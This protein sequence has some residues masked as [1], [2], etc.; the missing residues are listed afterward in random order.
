MRAL[1]ELQWPDLPLDQLSSKTV[2]TAQQRRNREKLPPA[3]TLGAL[4]PHTDFADVFEIIAPRK[5]SLPSSGRLAIEGLMISFERLVTIRKQVAHT[6]P[7]RLDDA[8]FV[9]DQ[10]TTL[11]T[12]DP[13]TW[14]AL[15][16]TMARI[17]ENPAYV[18]GL[19]PMW[20][21]EEVPGTP[22]HNLPIP[23]FDD[24]G[25][26]GRREE[27]KKLKRLIKGS[28]PVVSVLGNGGIGKTALAVEA[29]YE[30]LDDPDRQFEAIV[31]V[32]AKSSVMTGTEVVAIT[33]AIKDSL[34]LFSQAATFLG[35][36]SE[37][38]PISE[39][40]S[41]L[42][43]F[44]VLLILDNLE[45]VL[46]PVLREFLADIPLGSKVIVTSRISLGMLD[47]PISLSSLSPDDA[48]NLLY[49]LCRA[50]G[51]DYLRGVKR[52]TVEEY[53]RQMSGHPSYIRWFVAGLQAGRRPEDL[54]SDDGLVLRFCMSNVYDYLEDAERAA[55]GVFQVLSGPKNMAEL[56]Y[57]NDMSGDEMERILLTL[58]TTNF[59]SMSRRSAAEHLDSAYFLSDFAKDYLDRWHPIARKR[60]AYLL[61][62]NQELKAQGAQ[63]SV[64]MAATPYAPTTVTIRGAEDAHVARLLKQAMQTNIDA[65]ALGLCKE[66]QRLSPLYSESYRVEGKIRA[67]MLDDSGALESYERSL[68]LSELPSTRYHFALYLINEGIEV[69]RALDLL[70][71]GARLDPAS[72]EI[73]WQITW[74]HYVLRDWVYAFSASKRVL[75]ISRSNLNQRFGAVV[76]ALRSACQEI[77][78]NFNIEL[79]AAALELAEEAVDLAAS[80]EPQLLLDESADLLR[81]LRILMKDATPM[82]KGFYLSSASKIDTRISQLLQAVE[83]S[84]TRMM[85][86]I[87][88]L[89]PEKGF[90]FVSAVPEDYFLH[91]SQLVDRDLWDS[92]LEGER[93][94]FE[95]KELDGR[96]R[97]CNV[98]L[99][100]L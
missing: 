38:E 35:G 42:E 34:G 45:T 55:L 86:T 92:L 91:V 51:V 8:A 67:K 71:D 88:R 80:V 95:P 16:E 52:S 15:S 37:N 25:F 41:Y 69:K 48:V 83:P 76:I 81:Y 93:C 77:E 30:L 23:E 44:K 17:S 89:V 3:K 62:R 96:W 78:R 32:T 75:E 50:R 29:A 20:R 74:A 58:L 61:Q 46:D 97:A 99:L 64:E 66:A 94:F 36:S 28:Y 40:R 98:R 33:D 2:E 85:S 26:F 100:R 22:F 60:R 56:A 21:A 70:Q 24:T 18:L 57:L 1:A 9:A 19:T 63:L 39:L 82:L 68:N 72:S 73:A 84:T 31:W 6:K 87:K 54:L 65:E 90:G 27:L 12:A 59:V 53:A 4:L 7:M 79:P 10:A 5:A 14:S 49:A 13:A 43:S 11:V 47:N